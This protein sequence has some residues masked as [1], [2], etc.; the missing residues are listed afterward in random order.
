[1][2]SDGGAG[3]RKVAAQDALVR[4]CERDAELLRAPRTGR[5]VGELKLPEVVVMLD[6]RALALIDLD[7]DFALVVLERGEDLKVGPQF[8]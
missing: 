7:L 2:S 8:G 1:M 6:Q 4:D 3:G 5:D